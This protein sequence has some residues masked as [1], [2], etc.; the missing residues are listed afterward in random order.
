[1][2]TVIVILL[3]LS[4]SKVESQTF[5][6]GLVCGLNFAELEGQDQF[7]YFGLN[8]GVLGTARLSRHTQLT[9]ELLYSQNGEYILPEYY[10]P[11]E[12]GSIW[13]HHLEIPIHLDFLIGV[14]EREKYLDWHIQLGVAYAHIFHHRAETFDKIDVSS[15]VEYD[16]RSNVL[17]QA[18]TSY[19]FT[20]NL[21][22]NLR[23][24]L[25]I[26]QGLDWTVSTRIVYMI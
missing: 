8:A 24:S 21:L 5:D 15:L 19:Q 26:Q 16:D 25:P 3:V 11:I 1:M 20:Q 23:A 14:F 22:W 13:L 6:F 2:R 12:Y 7:S 9:V 10:P 4:T 17:L 18:G